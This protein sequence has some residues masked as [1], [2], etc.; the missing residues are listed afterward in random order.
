MSKEDMKDTDDRKFTPEEIGQVK[1][2]V[3]DWRATAAAYGVSLEDGTRHYLGKEQRCRM[4]LV[5]RFDWLE[6]AELPDGTRDEANAV[7]LLE[8]LDCPITR[9]TGHVCA[10]HLAEHDVDDGVF[11]VSAQEAADLSRRIAEWLEA[12]VLEKMLDE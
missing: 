10:R 7:A 12:E 1:L 4:C 11:A 9:A 2:A 8:C 5:N 6:F 3:S